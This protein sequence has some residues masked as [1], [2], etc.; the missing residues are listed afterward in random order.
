MRT[1]DRFIKIIDKYGLYI[2]NSTIN[3]K[4]KTLRFNNKINIKLKINKIYNKH[5]MQII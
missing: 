2:L 1:C 5:A 3:F 4:Y